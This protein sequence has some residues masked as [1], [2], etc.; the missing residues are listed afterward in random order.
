[1]IIGHVLKVSVDRK[2]CF[3]G[4]GCLLIRPSRS[5]L[6]D[7]QVFKVRTLNVACKAVLMLVGEDAGT[8]CADLGLAAPDS[9]PGVH[10]LHPVGCMLQGRSGLQG[11]GC[12]Q[13]VSSR[14][15]L[16]RVH[17]LKVKVDQWSCL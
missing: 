5:G 14:S 9:G 7:I 17:V 12:L 15:K 4:Q 1:M 3:K 16:I 10:P 2:S 13:V 11:Q 6:I 8:G